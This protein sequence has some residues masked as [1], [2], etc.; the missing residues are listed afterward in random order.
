MDTFYLNTVNL[1]VTLM[2]HTLGLDY[3]LSLVGTFSMLSCIV[4]Q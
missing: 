2:H 4:L 3:A 1:R